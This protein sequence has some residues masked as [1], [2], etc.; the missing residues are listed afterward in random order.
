IQMYIYWYTINDG[1]ET[2]IYEQSYFERFSNDTHL[3]AHYIHG[4]WYEGL[5]SNYGFMS[6]AYSNSVFFPI[7]WQ[8]KLTTV[9]D[10]KYL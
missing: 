2:L 7:Y 10:L 5:L 6:C 4:D 8:E 3:K 9:S 1:K